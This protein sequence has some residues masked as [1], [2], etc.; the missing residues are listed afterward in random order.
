MSDKNYSNFVKA[1]SPEPQQVAQNS[2][3]LSGVEARRIYLEE[4]K[5]TRTSS[6][7]TPSVLEN[8]KKVVK[9]QEQE[10]PLTNKDLFI[11]VQNN[12]VDTLKCVLDRYP[13]KINIVDDY[14]WSLLMIACQADSVDA[15]KLLLKRG[16]DMSVRD[17]GGNSAR[18]LVI[19]NKNY[20]L[21]D[22]LLRY[23]Q[24][25]TPKVQKQSNVKVKPK[26][27]YACEICNKTFPDKDE[28]LAST[29][30]NIS[31]SRGKKIPAKYVLPSSNR[32]YQLM[33]KGGWDRQSGLGRDGSGKLYPIKTV[34]KKDR[35]GLGHAKQKPIDN[36]EDY[37]KHKNRLKL[38]RDHHSD[39]SFEIKFRREFY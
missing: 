11:T 7:K 10:L 26:E 32:G 30:H 8:K 23:S 18:S 27:E 14:G 35:K 19:K 24:K 38:A 6:A 5:N 28:H 9:H 34:Q 20:I 4:L 12:D 17:K 2:G 21:A 25:E 15:V 1:S 22:I 31:A 13:D 36:T 37:V 3:T 16:I 29:I 39:K 33:L